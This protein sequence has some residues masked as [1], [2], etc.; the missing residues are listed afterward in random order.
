MVQQHFV[1]K[2]LYCKALQLYGQFVYKMKT[3]KLNNGIEMFDMK[4]SSFFDH[5]D[6]EIIEWMGNRKLD[7]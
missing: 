5:H 6:P 4:T 3:V 1:Y 7:I 2:L